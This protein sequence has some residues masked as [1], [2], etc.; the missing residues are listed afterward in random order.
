MRHTS[1]IGMTG[2]EALLS[3]VAAEPKSPAAARS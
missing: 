3:M 2:V 1:Y